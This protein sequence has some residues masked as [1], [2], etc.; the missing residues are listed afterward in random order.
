MRPRRAR[1]GAS[2]LEFGLVLPLA[3]L[4]LASVADWA[5]FLFHEMSMVIATGRG[6]RIAGGI[7]EDDGPAAAAETST[8]TWLTRFGMDGD[9]A[10]VTVSMDGGADPQ[11]ITV[12]GSMPYSPLVGMVPLPDQVAASSSGVYYGHLY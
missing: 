8:R 6:A 3:V 10:T 1:R 12:S 11:T 9:A 5:W 2:A 7:P 4:L